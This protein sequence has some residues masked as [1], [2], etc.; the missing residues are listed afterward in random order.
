MSC[1]RQ[2]EAKAY[3]HSMGLHAAVTIHHSPSMP[4][5][6]LRGEGVMDIFTVSPY[7]G[8]HCTLTPYPKSL[9]L[10]KNMVLP[11][12]SNANLMELNI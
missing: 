2:I 6:A 10:V 4:L 11:I 12:S 5:I 1:V 8:T 3:T 9:Q 7:A